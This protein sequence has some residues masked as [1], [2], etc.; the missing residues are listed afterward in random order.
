MRFL[1]YRRNDLKIRWLVEQATTGGLFDADLEAKLES[2]TFHRLE[3]ARQPS[4]YYD[5]SYLEPS[6]IGA[7]LFA[8]PV[9]LRA[10]DRDLLQGDHMRYR[11]RDER[12]LVRSATEL[13]VAF[14]AVSQAYSEEQIEQGLW[15]LF[16]QFGLFE[17]LAKEK[18][19]IAEGLSCVDAMLVP[20]RA[21]YQHASAYEGSVFFMWWDYARD[22]KMEISVRS[23]QVLQQILQLPHKG[24]QFAALHGLNHLRPDAEASTTIAQYLE[25]HRTELEP[26]DIAWIEKCRDGK[27]P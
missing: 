27:A 1:H 11:W 6:A 23:R 12:S 16:G 21:Y 9:P 24:C 5:L 20:F 26:K 3:P 4:I 8:R 7:F 19:P 25:V 13:F 10:S 17:E 2:E 22:Q 14:E 18:V 15:F